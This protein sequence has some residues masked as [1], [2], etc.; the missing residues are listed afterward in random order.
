MGAHPPR[1]STPFSC[2]FPSHAKHS[3]PPRPLFF[4]L[5]HLFP[6]APHRACTISYIFD[7]DG[8][9]ADSMCSPR[10][11]STQPPSEPIS[12]QNCNILHMPIHYRAWCHGLA[13][14]GGAEIDFTWE[15]RPFQRCETNQEHFQKNSSARPPSAA[16]ISSSQLFYSRAG[17]SSEDTIQALQQVQLRLNHIG[18]S[19][20]P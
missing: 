11:H 4:Y 19:S 3:P 5:L 17:M 8:T 6:L 15:V 14:G 20:K 7:L 18:S 2:I 16:L 10:P 12:L 13:S 1:P 9:L